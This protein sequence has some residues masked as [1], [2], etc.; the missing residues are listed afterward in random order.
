[1][2]V[3]W[4]IS[5]KDAAAREAVAAAQVLAIATECWVPGMSADR[6]QMRLAARGVTAADLRRIWPQLEQLRA[7]IR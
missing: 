5:E 7:R 3:P 6:H 4:K 2:V 1:M